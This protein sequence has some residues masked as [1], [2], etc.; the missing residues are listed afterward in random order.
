MCSSGLYVLSSTSHMEALE[1]PEALNR[2]LL[3]SC[4]RTRWTPRAWEQALALAA[5]NS[6]DW[7]LLMQ[8]IPRERVGPLLYLIGKGKGLF[9]P[10]LEQRL[11][12]FYYANL[13]RNLVLQ[14][15]LQRILQGLNDA[16][17]EAIVLK[18]M[19][20]AQVVYRNPAV[21]PM[22]DLDLLIRSDD[23]P[24]AV[25]KLSDMGYAYPDYL[26]EEL[27]LNQGALTSYSHHEYLQKASSQRFVVELHRFLIGPQYYRKHVP[28]EWFWE[29]AREFSLG[30]TQALVLG[31]EAMTIHLCAHLCLHHQG[32]KT[33]LGF[34]DIA[35]VVAG[36]G[37]EMDWSLLLD[38]A[39]QC[40]LGMCLR[41]VL[42]HLE[43]EWQV[44][45]P[46][47]I[48]RE[49]HDLKPGTQERLIFHLRSERKWHYVGVMVR[50]ADWRERLRFARLWLFPCR[51]Y[52]M[53]QFPQVPSWL[54]PLTYCLRLAGSIARRFQ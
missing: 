2:R 33:L 16:G 23:I 30:K 34:Q 12:D 45:I 39:R 28:L 24:K 40:R 4:L 6:I 27:D 35:E 36:Y 31:P 3:I 41:H 15:E 53:R 43:K 46:D 18:G 8:S 42:D 26:R 38:R 54:W 51:A 29:S 10:E 22:G 13:H 32:V 7:P 49:L 5:D 21:R 14:N 47:S 25:E 52:M 1:R 44:P 17:V 37:V 50:F 20:L 9:L 11:R 48:Q 19:A